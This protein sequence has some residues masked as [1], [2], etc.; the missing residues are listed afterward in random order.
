MERLAETVGTTCFLVSYPKGWAV[1]WACF[2]PVV[3]ARSGNIRVPQ[4]F[5]DLGDI[6]LVIERVGRSRRAQ[7][8]D[9]EAV[10]L[11][12]DA[13]RAAVFADDV[14]IDGIRIE[15]TVEF[16]RARLL[17]TGRNTGPAASSP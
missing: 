7:G 17:V 3:E 14:V 15:R 8:V 2:A 13:G 1:F 9:A 16:L 5:L 12:L 4:P 10:D 6:G 11:G